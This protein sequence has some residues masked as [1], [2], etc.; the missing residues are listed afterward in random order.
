MDRPADKLKT[1]EQ[2]NICLQGPNEIMPLAG[3]E[4]RISY[5]VKCINNPLCTEYRIQILFIVGTDTYKYYDMLH[6]TS[7]RIIKRI[8]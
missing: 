2:N 1:I 8:N 6:S 4:I 5:S 7:Y 3:L